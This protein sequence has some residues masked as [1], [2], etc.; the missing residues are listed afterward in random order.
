MKRT[1]LKRKPPR[2]RKVDPSKPDT[3]TKVKRGPARDPEHLARVRQHP[4]LIECDGQIIRLGAQWTARSQAH[5]VRCIAPRSLGKRVSDYLTVPLCVDC[6]SDLH[7]YNEATYWRAVKIDPAAW[8]ASF[9]EQGRKA[10]EELRGEA[11]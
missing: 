8:I 4:C 2:K 1:A 5:H 7:A 6:H 3:R 11:T 9:S 10:I